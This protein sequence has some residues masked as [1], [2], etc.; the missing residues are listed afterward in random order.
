MSPSD[1]LLWLHSFISSIFCSFSCFCFAEV[2]ADDTPAVE[3]V[4]KAD[5]KRLALLAEVSNFSKP[6]EL[7]ICY[8]GSFL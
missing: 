7:E 6:A 5:K 1:I 3:A 4:L 8:G 2:A